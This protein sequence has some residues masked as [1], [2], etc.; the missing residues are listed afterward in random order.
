ME[1]TGVNHVVAR[2]EV[3]SRM[4]A[5]YLFE[6]HVAEYTTDL[7]STSVIENDQD[8]QQFKM[9]EGNLYVGRTYFDSFIKMKKELNVIL[10]G[11]VV[12][13]KLIKDPK[14]DHQIKV[15][16]Y[17]IIISRGNDKEKLEDFFGIQ[18]GF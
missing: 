1:H 9:I 14:D 8:I 17:V 15:G 3:A 5:S 13:N 7:I 18:E 2:H 11:L 6:P 10:I 4:V 12:N 16:D